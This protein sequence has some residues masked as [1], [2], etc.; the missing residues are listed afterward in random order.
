MG[1]SQ[2]LTRFPSLLTGARVSL[3][4]H[5]SPEEGE[6]RQTD[7]HS[8]SAG[9]RQPPSYQ[10]WTPKGPGEGALPAW[11]EW[12]PAHAIACWEYAR[13]RARPHLARALQGQAMP[14]MEERDWVRPTALGI[15]GNSAW[16]VGSRGW[17]LL[18]GQARPLGLIQPVGAAEPEAMLHSQCPGAGGTAPGAGLAQRRGRGRAQLLIKATTCLR[19][20]VCEASSEGGR[21]DEHSA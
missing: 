4:V 9:C 5:A 16:G 1:T 20:R 10:L 17:G 18:K 13:L 6:T 7:L 14:A 19:A 2:T 3:A 21:P 8:V 15:Y 12:R 11:D